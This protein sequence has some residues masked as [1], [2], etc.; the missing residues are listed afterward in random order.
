MGE[1]EGRVSERFE[2]GGL[3]MGDGGWVGSWGAPPRLF[4]RVDQE[5]AKLATGAR[6]MSCAPF[7][8][9]RKYKI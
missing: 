6:D 4:K 9:R 8:R 3:V 5:E 2:G 7:S 1:S